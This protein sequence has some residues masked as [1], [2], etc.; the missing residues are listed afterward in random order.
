MALKPGPPLLYYDHLFTDYC[1]AA[2]ASHAP[3]DEFYTKLWS[4]AVGLR[5]GDMVDHF[6]RA[7]PIGVMDADGAV[8]LCPDQDLRMTE[9]T[10][11]IC[12]AEDD[13]LY[14]FVPNPPSINAGELPSYTA[15]KRPKE[16]VRFVT[17]Q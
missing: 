15:P 1:A 12:I 3:Q 11:L 8:T 5:F 4:E 6:P 7:I 2:L 16:K 10:A 9:T 14:E 13:D 17:R